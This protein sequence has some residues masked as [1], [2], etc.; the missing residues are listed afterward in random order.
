MLQVCTKMLDDHIK[1]TNLKIT[2]KSLFPFII[3]IIHLKQLVKSK[4]IKKLYILD[5]IPINSVALQI[6][7]NSDFSLSYLKK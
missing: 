1:L 7:F 2:S 5:L 4:L 6:N 3:V